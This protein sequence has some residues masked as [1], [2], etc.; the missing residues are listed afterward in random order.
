MILVFVCSIFDL[1]GSEFLCFALAQGI[2]QWGD[3]GRTVPEYPGGTL[4]GSLVEAWTALLCFALPY[5]ALLCCS[6]LG[7]SS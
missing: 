3:A 7:R 1:F 6:A 4:G 5:L 2:K